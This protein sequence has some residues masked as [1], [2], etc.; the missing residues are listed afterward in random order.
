VAPSEAERVARVLLATRSAGKIVELRAMFAVAEVP[1][2]DLAA[3][4]IPETP[5]EDDL[6]TGT[7]YEGNAL[8][9]ARY[10]HALTGLPT[11]ADDSGI[12][13]EALGGAPG[14]HSKRWSGVPL[15]GAAQDAANN[16]L[17]QRRLADASD[18]RARYVCVAA[19][20][21]GVREFTERGESTGRILATPRGS[22]GF[23]YD[24]YFESDELQR[25]F[26][27]VSMEEKARVSHRARAFNKLLQHLSWQR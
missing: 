1:A 3:E 19:Y 20:C 13:V 4:R 14:V 8:A 15:S 24:P 2:T 17:L 5:A 11:A 27:E 23:G 10:F 6:E 25:T 26:A 18:R 16:A 7:T 12:E 22:G 21:D 9:K